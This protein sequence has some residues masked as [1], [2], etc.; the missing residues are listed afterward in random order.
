MFGCNLFEISRMNQL[1]LQS[2]LS[3]RCS[4]PPIDRNTPWYFLAYLTTTLGFVAEREL[5]SRS[6]IDSKTEIIIIVNIAH[7]QG[8][9]RHQRIIRRQSSIN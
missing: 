3:C 5:S 4:G 2:S 1:I 7:S 6:F 8:L 9:P